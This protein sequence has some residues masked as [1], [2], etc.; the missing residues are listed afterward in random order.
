MGRTTD[1]PIEV[2]AGGCWAQ[3]RCRPSWPHETGEVRYLTT[4]VGGVTTPP[5]GI[6]EGQLGIPL[7]WPAWIARQPTMEPSLC[8]GPSVV[9][10]DV[11]GDG[12]LDRGRS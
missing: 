8:D 3:L 6:G 7:E 11:T 2:G 1:N 4:G 9:R 12:R 10:A 5:G